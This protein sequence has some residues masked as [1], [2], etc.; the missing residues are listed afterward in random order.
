MS[1]FEFRRYSKFLFHASSTLCWLQTVEKLRSSQTS[2]IDKFCIYAPGIANKNKVLLS[3]K[4]DG[5][6]EEQ[7]LNLPSS[8]FRTQIAKLHSSSH[9][10]LLIKRGRYPKEAG[11]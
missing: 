7:Y 8:H 4:A 3:T 1:I 2:D 10:D 9:D 5:F 11:A 6:G